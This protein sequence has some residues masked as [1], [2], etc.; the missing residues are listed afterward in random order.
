MKTLFL[1][2]TWVLIILAACQSKQNRDAEGLAVTSSTEERH[3]LKLGYA[4]KL[5]IGYQQDIVKV[6]IREPYKGAM[7]GLTYYLVPAGLSVPDS[8]QHETVIRTPVNRFVC[9]STTH[10]PALDLLDAADRLVGFP[11]LQFVSSPAVRAR[12]DAGHIAE[13]GKDLN[14]NTEQVLNVAPE[15]L[16]T[17]TMDG[18]YKHLAPVKKSGVN[19]IVNAD[20][21]ENTPLGRAEWIKLFGL[22][23]HKEKEADSVFNQIVANYQRVQDLA[24]GS[25]K[26]PSV[27]C[28]IDYQGVWYMPGGSS[29]MG[30]YLKDAG[31][32][33]FWSTDPG[34]GSIELSFETVYDSAWQADFW[35]NAHSFES[36]EH[37]GETDDRY[38][39]FRAF[40]NGSVYNSNARMTAQGGNDYY[41]SG[42][43]RPDVILKDLVKIFHPD[44]LPDHELYFFQK[45][46]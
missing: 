20:Y 32:S 43:A 40:Q 10:L 6:I 15:V 19:I 27:F 2:G 23:F 46:E 9:T 24:R 44:L 25:D 3:Q 11:S 28:G 16:M 8:L 17:F 14:L 39:R 31:T 1:S 33:Y 45:L 7:E 41:E 34:T 37:L 30:K 18:N 29:W 26:R 22:L 42:I 35:I 4:Q 12:A 36:L 38:K 5:D 13:L 21:L